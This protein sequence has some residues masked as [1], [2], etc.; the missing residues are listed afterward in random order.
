MKK[1]KIT[2]IILTLSLLFTGCGSRS[3]T[4]GDI[5]AESDFKFTADKAEEFTFSEIDI[6]ENEEGIN[7]FTVM[8]DNKVAAL[9]FGA[10]DGGECCFVIYENGRE[11]YRKEATWAYQG[12]C[13]NAAEKCFYTY[14]SMEKRLCVMDEEFNLKETLAEE[15]EAADLRNMIVIDNKLYLLAAE[16]NPFDPTIQVEVEDPETGYMNFDEKAYSIDLSTKELENLG[17]QNV[18]CQSYSNDTLYYF[19]CR[20]GHYSLDVY[21]RETG[22][23]KAV[24]NMDDVGYTIAFAV[25]GEEFLY[26]SVNSAGLRKLNLNTGALTAEA[27][28]IFIIRNSQF[29]VYRDALIYLDINGMTI[30]KYGTGAVDEL[31]LGS[32]AKYNGESLVIGYNSA[33]NAPVQTGEIV[34]ACGVSAS[35]YEIPMHD[36]ELKLELLSGNSDVDIYIFPSSIRLGRDLRATGGYVPLTDEGIKAAQDKYFD[37]LA[38]YCVNDNGDIWCVP[39]YANVDATYYVPD[40]LEALGVEPEELTTLDGYYSALEKVKS[41]DKYKFYGTAEMLSYSMLEQ[42]YPANYGWHDYDNDE[43]KN[44]FA[45]VYDGFVLWEDPTGIGSHPLFNNLYISE[46]WGH[47]QNRVSAEN[48][49]FMNSYNFEDDVERPEDWRAVK[50]PRVKS[51]NEKNGAL[52]SYA[53]VN[54]YSK[55]KEAAEAYLGYIAESGL[56]YRTER[57]FSFLYKDKSMYADAYDTETP[58]FNDLYSL[59]ENAAICEALVEFNS[60]S[61]VR[62]WVIEYQRGEIT[63]EEYIANI[64]RVSE[65]AMNE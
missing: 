29:Q 64:T 5:P 37:W 42:N 56:K 23:L 65:I 36:D 49:A 44:A 15:L 60:D 8:D 24:R 22:T 28:S 25:I 63:L 6:D 53:I 2:A 41:Q 19:T 9:T 26:Y 33:Y 13:F 27:G 21:D 51:S 16:K 11:I 57:S 10:N 59:N 46:E 58:Y 20:D 47:G 35:I 43:F 14:D 52:I 38:D 40:N 30:N 3:D 7:A 50:L 4:S 45:R 17:I 55:K 34:K 18:I 39:I 62:P 12:L 31:P 48:V 54:P 1:T 32:I 61:D